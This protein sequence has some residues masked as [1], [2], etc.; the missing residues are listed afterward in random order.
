MDYRLLVLDID[1]TTANS[2]KEV[3]DGTREAVVWLQR[4]GVQVVLASG[5]PP[6]GVLPI[7]G[8]L[9][10]PSFGSYI[11]AFNGGRIID[12]RSGR[13]IFEKR[14]PSHI[15]ARLLEDA[16]RE[17]VGMAVYQPGRMLAGTRP[18]RY[19]RQESAVS[20]LPI[21]RTESFGRELA[22]NECLLTGPPEYMEALQPVL[23]HKYFHEAQVFQSEPWYLEVTPKNVDKAYGLK[24]L[25]HILQIPR[26]AMVCC[27][28]SYNDVSMLQYAGLGAA[29][30][31]AAD[32][33]KLVADYVTSRDN[34]HDGVAEVI[35]RFFGRG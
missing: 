7:A 1:G 22:A 33:V 11:L 23:A 21:T 2:K 3:T 15:P 26:E 19:M 32:P 12:S 5:R 28:D 25:L 20:G 14:L 6:E 35:E 27:G 10:L 34:D 13:C 24:H 18:D 8:Q 4:R 17:G 29:M 16:R 9:E 30:A 31:N